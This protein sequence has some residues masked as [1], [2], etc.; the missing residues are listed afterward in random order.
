MLR[1][2]KKLR[3]RKAIAEA[4][5]RLFEARGFDDVTVAEIAEAAEITPKTLFSYFP[6]KED[7]LFDDEAGLRDM[8]LAGIGGRAPGETILG[9]V[10]RQ[11]EDL[12][13]TGN[14]PALV[15]ALDG[16]RRSLGDNPVLHARL[17]LMWERYEQAVAAMLAQETGAAPD[18]PQP[19][20][21]AVQIVA[22]YR[23]LVSD[24]VGQHLQ[25]HA[26]GTRPVAV[27]RWFMAA[28]DLVE[29]GMA[30]YG[31]KAAG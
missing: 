8:I 10:R 19:R 21:A 4:A 12:T 13:S 28:L 14:A 24:A 1:E 6:A 22:L 20:M 30:G 15:A 11:I 18:D 31:G 9:A 7:L 3:T 27:R 17:R 26:P 25:A 16:L 29:N 23:L 5:R 2:R